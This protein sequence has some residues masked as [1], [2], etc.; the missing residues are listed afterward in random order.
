VA[1]IVHIHGDR[2][3]TVP[4]DGR[5][6]GETRQGKVSDSLPMYGTFG[7]FGPAQKRDAGGLACTERA[8]RSGDILDF[9]LFEGGHSFRT[10][11]LQHAIERLKDAGQL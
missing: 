4:L 6:I 2:D 11:F 10:E 3:E 7:N 8:A 1:S 5:P 9:C